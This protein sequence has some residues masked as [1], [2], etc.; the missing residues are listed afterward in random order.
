ML[1]CIQGPGRSQGHHRAVREGISRIRPDPRPQRPRF[2]R[3]RLHLLH[4]CPCHR[5]RQEPRL[6]RHAEPRENV[7]N[8]LTIVTQEHRAITTCHSYAFPMLCHGE[9]QSMGCYNISDSVRHV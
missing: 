1:L 5:R 2:Q 3:G 7:R 6:H 4:G 8:T 9:H